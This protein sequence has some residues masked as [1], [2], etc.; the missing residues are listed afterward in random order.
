[1]ATQTLSQ[2]KDAVK[3]A[4]VDDEVTKN[5]SATEK[6][7]LEKKF[8]DLCEAI[9]SYVKSHQ[10]LVTVPAQVGLPTP[11]PFNVQ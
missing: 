11:T 3:T 1:M 9:D 10:V 7:A 5:L 6:A 4:L 8:T 2:F